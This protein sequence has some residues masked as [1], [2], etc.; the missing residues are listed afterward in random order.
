M[1]G[2]DSGKA[3]TDRAL[4]RQWELLKNHLPSGGPGLTARDLCDRLAEAGIKVSKRTVERDLLQLSEHFPLCR[5]TSSVPNGWYLLKSFCLDVPSLS[6]TECLS[7]SLMED[8]LLQLMPSSLVSPLHGKFALAR[9]KLAVLPS[10]PHA[11]WRELLRYVPPGMPM[12]PPA[13]LP[14]VLLAIQES[15]LG[16]CQLLVD[17][18]SAGAEE[19][20]PLTLHPLA[21]IQQGARSYLVATAFEYPDPK[22]YALHRMASATL[23][24]TPSQRPTGFS[25]D[26]YLASGAAQFGVSGTIRLK[27]CIGDALKCLLEETPISTD[28]NIATRSGKHTLTASVPDSWQLEFW[29]RS[30]G[31]EITVLQP[32][33]LRRRIIAALQASLAHYSQSAIS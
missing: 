5:N 29:I 23:I 4:A 15:L 3:T 30:Q 33:S 6:L 2:S 7:V 10:F 20:K 17:Y 19:T 26:A 27:A 31:T 21:L 22:L 8:L 25:L 28:Q 12:I 14:S 16:Q 9:S 24:S 18:Q 32:L 13:I 11:R 1:S